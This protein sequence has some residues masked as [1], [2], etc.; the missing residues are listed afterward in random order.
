[1]ING[2]YKIFWARSSVNFATVS[3]DECFALKPF[4]WE[5]NISFVLRYS[6][7]RLCTIFSISFPGRS[8]KEI[9]LKLL[10]WFL[11]PPLCNDVI[12]D[13]FH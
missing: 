2:I 3:R 9:G 12:F 4:C 5:I 7:I 11:G 8:S 6:V 1:M 10:I 13:N